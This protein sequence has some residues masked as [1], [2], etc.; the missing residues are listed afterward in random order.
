MSRINEWTKEDYEY[1][2]RSAERQIESL[3]EENRKIDI[4]RDHQKFRVE[5]ELEPMIRQKE[6]SYDLWVSSPERGRCE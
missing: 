1:A 6:R 5:N 3:K 4:D 2:L